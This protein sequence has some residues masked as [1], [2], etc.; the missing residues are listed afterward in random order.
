M[1]ASVIILAVSVLLFVYWFHSIC[2]LIIRGSQAAECKLEAT[3][4][5]SFLEAP[6]KLTT[7]SPVLL[8]EFYQV[9]LRDHSILTELLDGLAGP[10][11][12]EKRMLALDFQILQIWYS[13]TRGMSLDLT[14]S[15]LSDMSGIL[16]L[17][18]IEIGQQAAA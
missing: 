5:L 3:I 9:L 16:K 6:Q 1:I 17:F 15:A 13:L 12:A 7:D 2:A 10:T 4:R 11:S 14:R 18:A 8:D